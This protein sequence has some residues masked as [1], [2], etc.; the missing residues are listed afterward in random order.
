M[1]FSLRKTLDRSKPN[2][3]DFF[4][5]STCATL[6]IT[7][8]VNTL[9]QLQMI[10]TAAASI[11]QTDFKSLVCIFLAGGNDSNNLLVPL[12]ASAARTHYEQFRGVPLYAGGS[13]GIAIPAAE[14]AATQI[15]PL[16][17]GAYNP[18]SGYTSTLALHPACA[19][20]KALFDNEELAFVTNIGTLTE[21]GVTRA[22]FNNISPTKPPQLF[23]HADQVLQWQSSIADQPFTSGWGGRI[24]DELMSAA[25][26]ANEAGGGLALGVSIAGVNSFQVGAGQQPFVMG[27]GGALDFDGY[28]PSNVGYADAL[29]NVNLKPFISGANGYDPLT[30]TNYKTTG[31]GWR[32]KALEKLMAMNHANLFDSS[33]EATAKSARMTEGVVAETLSYTNGSAGDKP[34]LDS[35]FLS[36]FDGNTTLA[37]SDFAN[38]LK[39]VARLIIGNNALIQEGK[40]ANNRQTFF[41]QQGGYDTHASQIAVNGNNTVNTGVGQFALLNVLSRSVKAFHDAIKGHP[42]GGIALWDDVVGFTSSDFNRT[43]TPNK[44]DSTGGSDHGW[45]GHAFVFGGEVQGKRIYGTFPTLLVDDGIDCTGSRGRWIPTTSVDQYAAKFAQWIGV[46]SGRMADV[47]PNLSRFG[48]GTNLSFL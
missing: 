48:A 37:N 26:G 4:V 34:T 13:G 32:L 30:S 40:P 15:T 46:P 17:A 5:Q 14:L 10:G 19:G 38:Q 42:R 3:R 2:R 18:S 25:V 9:S 24:A 35:Y 45:G 20:L 47:L 8:M 36:A 22:N 11:P 7:S 31:Q 23:S 44:T 21:L 39:M 6:G 33:F 16:N 41:V 27:T 29:T 28:G 43:F 12:G 1:N